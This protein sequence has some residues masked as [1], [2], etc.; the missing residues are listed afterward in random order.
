MAIILPFLAAFAF[1]PYL[2]AHF[3]FFKEK[4][5]ILSTATLIL[6]FNG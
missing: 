5:G 1:E 2:I 3:S 6:N 4:L